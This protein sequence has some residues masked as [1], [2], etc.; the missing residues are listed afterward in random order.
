L[1][2]LT[3]LAWLQIGTGVNMT[4]VERLA[5]NAFLGFRK[6]FK[7]AG[8]SLERDSPGALD[9]ELYFW[10]SRFVASEEPEAEAKLWHEAYREYRESEAYD[11]MM[12]SGALLP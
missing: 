5:L 11:M 12:A 10:Q 1:N 9:D 4:E 7:D 2:T 6:Y 8:D 3:T